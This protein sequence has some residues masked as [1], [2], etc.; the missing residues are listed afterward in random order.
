MAGLIPHNRP[1]ITAQDR[2]AVDAVLASGWI[3]QGSAVAALEAQFVRHYQG[4]SACALTSGTAALF[5]ALKAL[6][7]SQDAIVAVPSY[8]CSALLNAVFMAGAIPRVVDVL[9][10][11]FCLDPKAVREQA[12]DARFAIAVHTFGAAA[13]IAALRAQGLTVIEDCCQSLGGILSGAPL[14]GVGDAAVFSFYATKIITGGQGGLIWS[15]STAVT[16]KARDYRQFDGRENY[17]PR[18]N[19]QLTDLQAAL[20]HSQLERI[21]SIRTRRLA[22]ADSYLAALP[23]G[24]KTQLDVAAP[25]RMVHRF[26]VV[27]PDRQIRDRL[28]AHMKAAGAACIV[29]VERFE[30]LHRYLNLDPA[31]YPVAEQLADTTL[32]LPLHLCLSDSDVAAIGGAL[33]KFQP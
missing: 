23:Q 6:G 22:M 15:R 24:L 11:S 5:L 17:E 7:A 20:A 31:G 16:E 4:G 25:S 28:H 14:G 1:F 21:E 2:A 13:D 8:A 33:T 18:F 10:E 30:L 26:V 19:F 9:P 32:S 3:A 27:T 29:P 12:R